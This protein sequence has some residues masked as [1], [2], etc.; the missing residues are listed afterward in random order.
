MPCFGGGMLMGAAARMWAGG[1][2]VTAVRYH[3]MTH[4]LRTLNL[5]STTQARAF[6]RRPGH[7]DPS[8][9]AARHHGSAPGPDQLF[10]ARFI[11]R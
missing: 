3:G 6:S 1:S 11:Q 5:M 4:D 7:L 8:G 9:R 10:T 2:A